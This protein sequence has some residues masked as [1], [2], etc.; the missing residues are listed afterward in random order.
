MTRVHCRTVTRYKEYFLMPTFMGSCGCHCTLIPG[1]ARG[2]MATCWASSDFHNL[3][4]KSS[5]TLAIKSPSTGS[6]ATSLTKLL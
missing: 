6:N 3:H 5:L 4:V 2:K 1:A